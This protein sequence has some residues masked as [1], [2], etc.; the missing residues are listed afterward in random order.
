M[1]DLMS[2]PRSSFENFSLDRMY[3][4]D[5][6]LLLMGFDEDDLVFMMGIASSLMDL[7]EM[8]G[9]EPSIELASMHSR[10]TEAL[11]QLYGE[12]E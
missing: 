7:S 4:G 12:E 2:Y 1:T 10:F 5:R 6:E 8:L 11:N 3:E 9:G